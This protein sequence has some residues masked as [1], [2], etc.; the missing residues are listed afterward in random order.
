MKIRF[1]G[2]KTGN[3]PCKYY[4]FSSKKN[5]TKQIKKFNYGNNVI[6]CISSSSCWPNY[7]DGNTL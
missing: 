7:F 6:Y 2:N 3:L 4:V 1:I 5:I